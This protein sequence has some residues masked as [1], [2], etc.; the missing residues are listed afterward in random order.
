MARNLDPHVQLAFSEEAVALGATEGLT[1]ALEASLGVVEA[2][3]ALGDLAGVDPAL[4]ERAAIFE[5]SGTAGL[6]SIRTA[7]QLATN[8]VRIVLALIRGDLPEAERL[9]DGLEDLPAAN[10]VTRGITV[11]SGR[12]QVRY[13]P[14]G[15]PARPRP[16]AH[17]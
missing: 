13:R 2:R 5:S 10:P 15:P 14:H 8:G 7:V 12:T 9:I 1:T 11:A 4:A 6:P 16:P 17:S 3:I